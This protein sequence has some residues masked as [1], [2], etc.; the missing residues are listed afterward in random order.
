MSI[1]K[2]YKRILQFL[3]KHLPGYQV[4]RWLLRSA[5][6]MIRK[7]VYIG[8]AIITMDQLQEIAYLRVAIPEEMRKQT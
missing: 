2:S 5:A 7:D 8:E 6:Y 1:W 4:R 3:A